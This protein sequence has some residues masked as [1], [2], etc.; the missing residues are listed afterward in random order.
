MDSGYMRCQFAKGLGIAAAVPTLF[1][2][3]FRQLSSLSLLGIC[4]SLMVTGAVALSA[5]LDPSREYA[6]IN[7]DQVRQTVVFG[8]GLEKQFVSLLFMGMSTG[9]RLNI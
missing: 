2:T 1:I 4:C 8:G 5:L 7:S 9:G 6:S 3:S